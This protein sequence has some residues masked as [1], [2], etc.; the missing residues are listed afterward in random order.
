LSN[1]ENKYFCVEKCENRKPAEDNMSCELIDDIE[2]KCVLGE[3]SLKNKICV[4]EHS[5]NCDMYKSSSGCSW[6]KSD[7]GVPNVICSWDE[8]KGSCSTSDDCESLKTVG[9]ECEDYTS[10]K[11]RCFLNSNDNITTIDKHCSD[12]FDVVR[13]NEFQSLNLCA[14]ADRN[15]YVNLISNSENE[16]ICT[17]DMESR[18]CTEKSSNT[19]TPPS[20]NNTFTTIII[21]VIVVIVFVI[22][23]VVLILIIIILYRRSVKLKLEKGNNNSDDKKT[24]ELEV[25]KSEA[26]SSG[27]ERSRKKGGIYYLV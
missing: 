1:G 3:D 10:S 24:R 17:W 19:N 15:T 26:I 18:T 12:V 13:C 27:S 20:K 9:V 2:I 14:Y 16:Y 25:I 4:V 7:K 22:S 11:G 5:M 8:W 21:V 6:S 23:I